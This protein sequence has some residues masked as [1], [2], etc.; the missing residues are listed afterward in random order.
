MLVKGATGDYT[1]NQYINSRSIDPISPK[2]SRL[3][4]RTINI[5]NKTLFYKDQNEKNHREMAVIMHVYSTLPAELSI[6]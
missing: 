3:N 6:I 5:H 4:T 1:R 2:Y